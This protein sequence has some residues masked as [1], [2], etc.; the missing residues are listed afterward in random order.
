MQEKQTV[1]EKEGGT[2]KK[3][4]TQMREADEVIF[5]ILLYIDRITNNLSNVSIIIM[6]S[7]IFITSS[8]KLHLI[9]IPNTLMITRKDINVYN[10]NGT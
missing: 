7:K 9:P 1:W 4:Q 3:R 5:I 2:E 8:P 6:Y 10:Y